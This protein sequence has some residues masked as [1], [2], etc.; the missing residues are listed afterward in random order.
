MQNRAQPVAVDNKTKKND[1]GNETK[2]KKLLTNLVNSLIW[3]KIFRCKLDQNLSRTEKY[4][5]S[6]VAS[7]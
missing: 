2:N 6:T 1:N 7:G 5:L 3:L 4:T